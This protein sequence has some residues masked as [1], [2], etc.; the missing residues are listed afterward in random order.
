[1]RCPLSAIPVALRSAQGGRLGI[2]VPAWE[3]GALRLVWR[4]VVVSQISPVPAIGDEQQTIDLTKTV[5][6]YTPHLGER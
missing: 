3:G 4:V 2:R 5:H 1:M 6:K